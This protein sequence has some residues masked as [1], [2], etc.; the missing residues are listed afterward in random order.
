[1]IL[2]LF[3]AAGASAQIPANVEL[4]GGLRSGMT[5]TDADSVMKNKETFLTPHCQVM[6]NK[7]F[8][9]NGLALV[10]LRNKWKL[11]KNDCYQP[12]LTTLIEK[13]GQPTDVHET[14]AIGNII[15]AGVANIWFQGIRGINLTHRGMDTILTYFPKVEAQEPERATG[16]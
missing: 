2:A 4:Y 8:Q 9:N 5:K 3:L 14:N 6:I 1:M 10:V 13:Y 11:E 12:I 16:L 7:V 15:P